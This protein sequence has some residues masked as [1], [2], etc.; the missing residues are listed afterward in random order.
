MK[1][2]QQRRA[3]G[4]GK[5]GL[6][7]W[8][9]RSPA[10]VAAAAILGITATVSAGWIFRDQ[11]A[12][13]EQSIQLADEAQEPLPDL[14]EGQGDALLRQSEFDPDFWD[15]VWIEW[16]KKNGIPIDVNDQT[17]RQMYPVEEWV[18]V[19]QEK[20]EE[21]QSSEWSGPEIPTIE[22]M[23]ELY[24]TGSVSKEDLLSYCSF[25][26]IDPS[27]FGVDPGNHPLT[28]ERHMDV[29]PCG[30]PN[31]LHPICLEAQYLHSSPP[32]IDDV[33]GMYEDGRL[34]ISDVRD[35]CD[36]MGVNPAE[37]VGVCPF[38]P[39]CPYGSTCNG[40][41]HIPQ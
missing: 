6:L 36:Q 17:Y 25:K 33:R 37:I 11:F 40:E 38:M 30:D 22:Q 1:A 10:A 7:D 12:K 19:E 2:S 29:A 41:F 32:P 31:C 13:V 34:S 39:D 9:R 18:Q 26:G 5:M 21:K 35:Y 24:S 23:Q 14:F 15:K 28:Y 3:K 20:G 8:A 27:M 4:K 16:A